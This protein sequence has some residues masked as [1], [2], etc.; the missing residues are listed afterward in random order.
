LRQ[1]GRVFSATGRA[2]AE[3]LW[4]DFRASP[5]IFKGLSSIGIAIRDGIAI[6][7][8]VPL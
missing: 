2:A 3:K 5:H 8:S 4:C 1:L 6:F 7:S